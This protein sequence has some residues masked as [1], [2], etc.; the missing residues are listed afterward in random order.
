MELFKRPFHW[1]SEYSFSGIML[2]FFLKA[3]HDKNNVITCRTWTV[4][5]KV[6]L[7]RIQ[8]WFYDY[9]VDDDL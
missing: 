4:T 3:W 2:G 5:F 6:S 7:Q 9:G 8:I 1:E